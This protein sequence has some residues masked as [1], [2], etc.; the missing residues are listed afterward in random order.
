MAEIFFTRFILHFHLNHFKFNLSRVKMGKKT[1]TEEVKWRIVAYHKLDYSENNIACLTGVSPSCVRNTISDW[2]ETGSKKPRSGRPRSTTPRMDRKMFDLSRSHPQWLAKKIVSEIAAL[3]IRGASSPC[4]SRQ[5][6]S[7]WL[8]EFNLV[9]HPETEKQLLIPQ[10][11]TA[12]FDCD[13]RLKN[14]P[15]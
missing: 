6:V 5:T 10:H 13:D 3:N 14:G 1:V 12:R 2:Q 8:L 4:T 11:K 7:R 9:S 15:R